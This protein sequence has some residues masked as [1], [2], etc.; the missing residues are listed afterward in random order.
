MKPPTLLSILVLALSAPACRP[1]PAVVAP[2]GGEVRPEV[3]FERI[4][5]EPAG[6][7]EGEPEEEMATATF[8][9]TNQGEGA[10]TYQGYERAVPLYRT[11]V[12]EAGAWQ[13]VPTGWCGTGLGEQRLEP[14]QSVEIQFAFAR[15]GRQHRFSFGAPEVWTPTVLAAAR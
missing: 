1:A 6:G 9:V 13:A 3:L 11:E 5:S 8:R 12:L 15:D 10:V 4:D 14:G 2:A 7:V